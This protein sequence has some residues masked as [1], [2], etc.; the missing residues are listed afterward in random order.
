M[1]ATGLDHEG[2]F[3]VG[4]DIRKSLPHDRG[5]FEMA[6]KLGAGVE[7]FAEPSIRPKDLME[8]HHG[9]SQSQTSPCQ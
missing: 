7:D 3:G 2:A 4:V 9:F 1:T 8:I 5:S 6:S